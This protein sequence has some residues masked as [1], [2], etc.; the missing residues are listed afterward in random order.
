MLVF[1]GINFFLDGFEI[2]GFMNDGKIIGDTLSNGVNW[3]SE[4]P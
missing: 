2:H 4:R 1:I 3:I